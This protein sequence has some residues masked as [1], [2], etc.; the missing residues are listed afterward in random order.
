LKRLHSSAKSLFTET[1]VAIPMEMTNRRESIRFFI[2]M[3][4]NYHRPENNKTVNVKTEQC[5]QRPLKLTTKMTSIQNYNI[6]IN[7]THSIG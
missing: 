2:F 3:F 7:F 5:V 4:Y 1:A 6:D